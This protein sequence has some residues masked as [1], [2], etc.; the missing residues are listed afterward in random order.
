LGKR[1][2][3]SVSVPQVPKPSR[4]LGRGPVY[5]R[6]PPDP[7]DRY[8]ELLSVLRQTRLIA[9]RLEHCFPVA[10]TQVLQVQSRQAEP[11]CR[12]PASVLGIPQDC[13][14]ISAHNACCRNNNRFAHDEHGLPPSPA[15]RTFHKPDRGLRCPFFYNYLA[16][17]SSLLTSVLVKKFGQLFIGSLRLSVIAGPQRF[18]GA[19]LQMIAKEHP[20]DRAQ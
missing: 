9:Q 5:Q 2:Q 13:S 17:T 14:R 3:Q 18:R 12:R 6:R 7:W 16:S 19:M 20:L 8:I 4:T 15:Q 1:T 10:L 11:N